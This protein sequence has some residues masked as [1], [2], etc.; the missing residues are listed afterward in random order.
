[1]SR[2]V[3]ELPAAETL[4]NNDEVIVNHVDTSGEEQEIITSRMTVSNL[5]EQ[6]GVNGKADKV[7]N[8]TNGNFA[9]L[10]S[11]GNLTDSG[12]K[13]T[14]FA[15]SS[16]THTKSQITDF[17][18]LGTAAAK[19]ST[20]AVTSGS[21]ALVE[22]GA[23]KSAIDTA[24]SSAYHHAGTKTCA[25]LTSALLI[26]A[27]EGNVYNITDSG[28]TTSDFIEGAGKPIKA[29]DNVGVCKVGNDY[30]FDLLSGFVDLTGKMDTDGSNAASSVKFSGKFTVG[31]R[32]SGSTEGT[33]SFASG[34]ANTASGYYS[35]AEGNS[36]IASN[37]CSHSEG[38]NTTASG[39]ESH[40]EGH[41]TTASGNYSHAEGNYTT[42]GY[43]NQ[44]VS[45]TYNNNKSDTLF[46]V[47]NGTSSSSKSNALEVYSNGDL[48]ITGDYKKNGSVLAFA[49][50]SAIGTNET[51]STAS[52]AYAIGDNFYKNGKFCTAIA[53]IASG[54]TF[55]L[56]TN[57][58]E[59]TIADAI[60]ALN[61]GLTNLYTK[62]GEP[63]IQINSFTIG[64]KL[65]VNIYAPFVSDLAT[66]LKNLLVSNSIKKNVGLSAV[67]LITD[68]TNTYYFK[69]GVYTGS[70]CA[71]EV[72]KPE[73]IAVINMSLAG[74]GSITYNTHD[75]DNYYVFLS[76]LII[77]LE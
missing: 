48:N 60:T 44:H 55:T 28:T 56:N 35:H 76:N 25:E 40:S 65:F 68:T 36:T 39:E 1:M 3:S 2:K 54:A 66:K 61:G 38:F 47:G 57:Y 10:N 11:S 70:W 45:G 46:E 14:D 50:I 67:G 33:N 63:W 41:S 34:D 29:G 19:D 52:K 4:T 31:S 20:N 16:H 26:A 58:V 73:Q 12:K 42:A 71:F 74:S 37:Q 53:A 30:K 43:A 13:S 24:V 27:N 49:D 23:V 32:A 77:P 15:A 51:G 69:I 22:S 75:Y 21:T 6:L 72:C 18:T 8:A 7:S 64:K 59:G 5:K 17:P 9:G 62:Q